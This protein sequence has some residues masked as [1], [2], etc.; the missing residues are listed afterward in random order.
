MP[1][2]Y[3]SVFTLP[4][5]PLPSNG[6]YTDTLLE[7][8]DTEDRLSDV[9]SDVAPALVPREPATAGGTT[10][11]RKAE[12]A[13]FLH[14]MFYRLPAPYVSLDASKPWLMYWTVHSLDLMGI[15][16]DPGTTER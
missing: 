4:R 14:S 15:G 10:T 2:A 12:H 6:V 8:R 1:S 9:L 11:L 16:L 7:Q 5:V 13:L 3:P